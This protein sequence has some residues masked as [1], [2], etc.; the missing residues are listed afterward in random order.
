MEII[1]FHVT[2]T[3]KAGMNREFESLMQLFVERT[4]PEPGTLFYNFYGNP[5]K[6]RQYVSIEMYANEQA[7]IDH[8]N[9]NPDLRKEAAALTDSITLQVLG[10]VS[11][12]LREMLKAQSYMNWQEG[13][14]PPL[15]EH[16]LH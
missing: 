11:P 2:F 15:R 7:V 5:D 9:G 13:V 4:Q 12:E 16:S 3:V 1:T 8:Q 10:N 6:W 14:E